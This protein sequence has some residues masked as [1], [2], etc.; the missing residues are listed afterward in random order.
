MNRKTPHRL[1]SLLVNGALVALAFGLFGLVIRKHWNDILGVFSRRLNPWVFVLG[2]AIYLAGSV[3]TYYRWWRLVRV[4]DA[5]FRLRDAV[6]L[7]FI[8][9]VFNLVIPG[10]VGG[11]LI[12]AAYLVKMRVDNTRAIA[13]MVIDRIVGLLGLFL[14]AAVAGA[15]A[16]AGAAEPLPLKVRYLIAIA[17]GAVTVG[18]MGLGAVFNE[19]LT[20]RYPQLLEGYGRLS[21]LLH[22]LKAVSRAYRQN[23]R[24]VAGCL[25]LS[26]TSHALSVLA[27]YTVSTTLFPTALPSIAQHLLLVPLTLFTM[28][29]PLPFG[30]LGLGE[31]VS[32]ELFKLVNHP[33]GALAM[34][35]FRVLMYGGGLV[36][37]FFYLTH[38]GQVRAL[39]ETAEHLAEEISEGEIPEEPH[40]A[41]PAL[42]DA[43]VS[44]LQEDPLAVH[45]QADE[46][47]HG[48][49]RRLLED[50]TV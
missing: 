26:C 41:D 36:S 9:N 27:W 30:A 42:A 5:G 6:L 21:S 43:R 40:A 25:A 11:D 20:R 17:W 7:G 22:E 10:A 39:T 2:F 12:K 34:M 49:H 35:G 47:E 8:G 3:L 24:V 50:G 16:W 31:T 1:R 45:P 44:D 15:V 32:D 4:L 23:L 37:S 38:L 46:P 13:S 19:S 14:L 33:E 29:A 48:E 28:A 18:F